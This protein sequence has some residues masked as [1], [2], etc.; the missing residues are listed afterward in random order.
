[1]H[2]LVKSDVISYQDRVRGAGLSHT[3]SDA[4]SVPV[5]FRS[6][7]IMHR[8]PLAGMHGWGT[9][10]QPPGTW[11]DDTLLMLCTME[12]LRT[13]LALDALEQA[14]WARTVADG[15]V[16]HNDR[17]VQYV[18]ICCT[19]RLAGAGIEPSLGTE[20]DSVDRLVQQP[21][22][23][24][25]PRRYHTGGTGNGILS[26]QKR[27]RP[28]WPDSTKMLSVIPEAVHWQGKPGR[29]EKGRIRQ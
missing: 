2:S 19:E 28:W 22:P 1:M 12:A 4:L 26:G 8:E 6:R 3:L 14:L 25:T 11:S 17:G 20:G 9:H 23:A 21:A 16:H 15:L 13:D 18:T 5:E 27:P 29:F 24:G 7:E 10:N